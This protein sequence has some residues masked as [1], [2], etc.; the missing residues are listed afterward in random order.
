MARIK[1]DDEYQSFPRCWADLQQAALLLDSW[2]ATGQGLARE[3]V[4]RA[5]H[6]Q[7]LLLD[8]IELMDACCVGSP[9]MPLRTWS[10]HEERDNENC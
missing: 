10:Q 1:D 8:A 7:N 4:G 9:G 6:V 2:S 5:S 3:N